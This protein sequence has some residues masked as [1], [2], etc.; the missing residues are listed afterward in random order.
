MSKEER[1]Q[2]TR[3]E[4]GDDEETLSGR[5]N[6]IIVSALAIWLFRFTFYSFDIFRLK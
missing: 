3:K 5:E 1:Q 6:K 4:D 2:M